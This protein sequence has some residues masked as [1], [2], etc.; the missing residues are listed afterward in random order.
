MKTF[1][2]LVSAV[3]LAA[4]QPMATSTAADAA[5][6]GK[7]VEG[8]IR[9]L[10]VT[11]ID[12]SV[13]NWRAK[14]AALRDELQKDARMRME[15]LD[16]PA[17]LD[18]V[19]MSNY[20]LVVLNFFNRDTPSPNERARENLRNFVDRGGGL[21]IIHAAAGAFWDWREYRNM[22][23]KVWNHAKNSLDIVGP[24]HVSILD[25]NHPITRG[26][27]N[28]HTV[29][30]LYSGLSGPRAVHILANAHASSKHADR[31]VAFVL[32]Y[33]QGRVFHT[34]L[35]HTAEA[36]RVPGTAM[37]IRRGC[38]WA[39]NAVPEMEVSASPS[40]M[41]STATSGLGNI[42]P[43]T[44]PVAATAQPMA[45]PRQRPV[46][47]AGASVINLLSLTDPQKDA[48]VGDWKLT[49]D[50]LVLEKPK[51]A[52]VLDLPY[53][54]PE[55]YDFEI[56]FTPTGTGMNVNQFL[57]AG[58]RAFAW[59]VA[60]KEQFAVI[61]LLD[62]KY[63]D[64]RKE[65]VSEKTLTL[66]PGRRYTSK[67]EVRRGSLRALVNGEEYLRWSGDFNRLSLE[68]LWK[69]H[70]D[71]HLGV[72]SGRRGVIFHRIEVREVSGK[73]QLARPAP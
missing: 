67:V 14:T 21:A 30:E 27:E 12:I 48:V 44:K 25:R 34:P 72:G 73:G 54:P 71:R 58:G 41:P 29:D 36:I 37:L 46:V 13:H 51:L 38:A 42:Q 45:K 55:E 23:G 8:S 6:Y 60:R 11:G 9:V 24:M 31:P 39:A 40:A 16:D 59:K 33:G 1:I 43:T 70:D 49:S 56:E 57:S 4:L 3:A 68:P 62:G 2:L 50:G 47:P 22:A 64:Q 15:V 63:Y 20:Q 61:E 66:E 17:G 52:G 35:G 53:A 69:L 32:T 5:I 28:Y 65:G 10:V 18:A 19:N 7:P 26:M